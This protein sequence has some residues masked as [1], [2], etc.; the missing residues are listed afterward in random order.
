MMTTEVE[1]PLVTRDEWKE[2]ASKVNLMV[3]QE[4]AR[5]R[6]GWTQTKTKLAVAAL[7]DIEPKHLET[8]MDA[9]GQ[10]SVGQRYRTQTERELILGRASLDRNGTEL[11][12][13]S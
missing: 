3:D 6:M 13:K 11:F 7:K 2:R 4:E 12:E 10:T 9:M 1:T 5:K 8:M